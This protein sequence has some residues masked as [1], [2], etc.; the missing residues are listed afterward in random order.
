[1]YFW[2]FFSLVLL[3]AYKLER[4]IVKTTV[5]R[6]KYRLYALRDELR[7]SAILKKCDPKNWL[8][9]YLDTSLSK[10]ISVLND[11]TV[12]HAVGLALIH[13]RDPVVVSSAKRLEE[14]LNRPENALFREFHEQFAIELLKFSFHRHF[15]LRRSLNYLVKMVSARDRLRAVWRGIVRYQMQAPETSTLHNYLAGSRRR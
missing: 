11:L 10:M 7:E 9:Q 12:W 13:R 5:M 15:V 6:H 4:D 2:L 8:F 1:M 3:A 14:E